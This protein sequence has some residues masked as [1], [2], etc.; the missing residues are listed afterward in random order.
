MQCLF[1]RRVFLFLSF[2]NNFFCRCKILTPSFELFHCLA[3]CHD[4]N[5]LYKNEFAICVFF[6]FFLE[7]IQHQ[8]NHDMKVM[9]DKMSYSQYRNA[10]ND[11]DRP[12]YH[13]QVSVSIYQPIY[14]TF[15]PSTVSLDKNLA[16]L[17]YA[18]TFLKC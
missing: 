16:Y 3:F 17:R 13:F 18:F 12:T 14:S 5:Y 6:F 11:F 10:A 4:F 8:Y 1:F 9:H 2:S 7:T 15:Y